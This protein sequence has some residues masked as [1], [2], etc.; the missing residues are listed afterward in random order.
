MSSYETNNVLIC[1]WL[2]CNIIVIRQA[3]KLLRHDG[4]SSE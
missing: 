2:Y 3:A 4:Y 1:Y